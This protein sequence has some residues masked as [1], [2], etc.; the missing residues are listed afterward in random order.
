ML[1]GF[2]GLQTEQIDVFER[3]ILSHIGGRKKARDGYF[4]ARRFHTWCNAHL[5][6]RFEA[7]NHGLAALPVEAGF[8]HGD[9]LYA[10]VD[11]IKAYPDDLLS[12]LR[13][14]RTCWELWRRLRP[15]V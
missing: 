9:F 12:W 5:P 4:M 13:S 15:I 14:T 11:A 6:G 1:H 3:E 7:I 8:P 2:P 10:L